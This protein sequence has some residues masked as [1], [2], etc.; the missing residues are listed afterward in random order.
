MATIYHNGT[1][2]RASVIGA[3]VDSASHVT[4]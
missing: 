4:I 1:F 2:H 3:E